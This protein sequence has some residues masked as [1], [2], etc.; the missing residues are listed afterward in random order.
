MIKQFF[1]K[2]ILITLIKGTT[3]ILAAGLAFAGYHIVQTE[4]KL[5]FLYDD[6]NV[7]T[8]A[9]FDYFKQKNK[10]L[11]QFEKDL[12]EAY[13]KPGVKEEY[14]YTVNMRNAFG[15]TFKI[16]Y[17]H[18]YANSG[19]SLLKIITTKIPYQACVRYLSRPWP[20][21]LGYV[22][23]SD[24]NLYQTPVDKTIAEKECIAHAESGLTEFELYR[25]IPQQNINF[26]L[27]KTSVDYLPLSNTES[28]ADN[29]YIYNMQPRTYYCCR[30]T[31]RHG[32]ITFR[33]TRN[34]SIG[35]IFNRELNDR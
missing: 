2:K 28:S 31:R 5:N 27:D 32:N 18:N 3:L 30:N 17:I 15:G 26:L 6:T 10:E 34:N 4:K 21:S 20:Q 19:K 33:I 16:L 7:L 9:F 13:F 1:S 8:E 35:N 12:H 22:Y 24:G 14:S 25:E 29:A 11:T 23:S